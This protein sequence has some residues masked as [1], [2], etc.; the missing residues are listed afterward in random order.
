MK[1]YS[2]ELDTVLKV[3]SYREKLQQQNYARALQKQKTLEQRKQSIEQELKA[4]AE[5][6]NQQRGSLNARHFQYIQERQQQIFKMNDRIAQA[7]K[8]A[9]AERK[10]LLEARKKTQV[11]ENLEHQHKLAWMKEYER[12]EQKQMNEIATIRYNRQTQ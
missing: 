12:E 3:R 8:N 10:K 5:Y 1:K 11:M 2:F 7:K 6:S 9:E 4:Y